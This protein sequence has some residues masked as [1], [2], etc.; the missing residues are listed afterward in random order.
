MS[1]DRISINVLWTGG[2]DSTYLVA[3]LAMGYDC[4]IQP[5]YIMDEGRAST[6]NEIDAITKITE[7]I[8]H[9]ENVRGVVLDPIMVRKRDII[10]DSG[11]TKAW[12]SLNKRYSIGIQYEFIARFAKEKGICLAVGVMCDDR[13]KIAKPVEA[14]EK[15]VVMNELG[16][17]YRIQCL[18]DDCGPVLKNM[19]FPVFM[20]KKKKTE[21]WKELMALGLEDVASMTWF[22]HTPI[23]GMPCGHCNPCKDALAEGMSFRVPFLGR[24]LYYVI[25]LPESLIKYVLR[26]K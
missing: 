9:K 12:K 24:I 23:L 15:S 8:R 6:R 5:Y 3:R 4:N 14:E 19:L 2:L 11:I 25:R 17:Y 1:K 7:S 18:N 22:C 10:P 16:G 26:I 13:S 20:W 21:E